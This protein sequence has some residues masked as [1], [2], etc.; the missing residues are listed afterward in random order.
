M[1]EQMRKK[2]FA[3]HLGVAPSYITK[4]IEHDR[5]VLTEDRKRVLVA[6]SIARLEETK[7]PNRDD[8]VDRWK[9]QR[10]T[11]E[12]QEDQP[13][14]P[15]DES[16]VSFTVARARKEH[17]LSLKAEREYLQM[18]GNLCEVADVRK[19]GTDIGTLVRIKIEKQEHM[20]ADELALESDPGRVRAL[21]REYNESILS[22]LSQ[23]IIKSIDKAVEGAQ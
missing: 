22:E 10:G 13:Q 12:T 5:L 14:D 11:T 1:S 21:I 2:D 16:T 9:R 7:D 19:A 23:Q 8:V 15:P 20:L 3:D 4:L 18:A 6:E 17:F